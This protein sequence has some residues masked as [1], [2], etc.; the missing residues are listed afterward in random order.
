MQFK[1]YDCKIVK[2][3]FIE[4]LSHLIISTETYIDVIKVK[5]GIKKGNVIDGTYR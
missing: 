3:D 4:D 1:M 2:I 5:R